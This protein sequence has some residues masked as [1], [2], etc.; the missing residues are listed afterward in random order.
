MVNSNMTHPDIHICFALYGYAADSS[1]AARMYEFSKELAADCRCIPDIAD[2]D[3][4]GESNGKYKSF[5]SIDKKLTSVGFAGVTHW[6][7]LDIPD[8]YIKTMNGH[9]QG[10][11]MQVEFDAC[12]PIRSYVFTIRECELSY[13][14][15]NFLDRMRQAAEILCPK[16]G[17][18]Y[19]RPF[20]KGPAL[21]GMGLLQNGNFSMDDENI[22]YWPCLLNNDCF[23]F[24]RSV[25]T[26]QLLT[27]IQL[28]L[29]IDSVRLND[30]ISSDFSRGTLTTFSDTLSLWTVPESNRVEVRNLLWNEGLILDRRRHFEE[31][32]SKYRID[33]DSVAQHYSKQ[34]PFQ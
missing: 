23:V 27:S 31:I 12:S 22:G 8:D 7:L 33:E 32:I 6:S 2:A 9:L 30:W 1:L 18:V 20:E 11:K 10:L 5:A 14:N 21:Y 4:G 15:V 16:Y 28:S 3:I 19:R 17:I 24:L 29:R 34:I 25:Y 26:E 13:G